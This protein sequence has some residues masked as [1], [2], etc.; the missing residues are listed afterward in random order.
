MSEGKQP[1]GDDV[2]AQAR[3]VRSLA[4]AKKAQLD[5][6]KKELEL[7]RLER[8]ERADVDASAGGPF[9]KTQR[10]LAIALQ[11]SEGWISWAKKRKAPKRTPQGWDEAAWRAWIE[12]AQP[13]G[14]GS[15][16]HVGDEPDAQET[17][18]VELSEREEEHLQLLTG[19]VDPLDMSRAAMRLAGMR[20]D[21]SYRRG[22][23]LTRELPNLI[24]S[25]N[26]LR[27]AEAAAI[28]LDERRGRLVSVDVARV[29]GNALARALVRALTNYETSIAAKVEEWLSDAN[30]RDLP[31]EQ[32][33]RHVTEWARTQGRAVRELT[34]GELAR[35]MDEAIADSRASKLDGSASRT[36]R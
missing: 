8:R 1:P 36:G 29:A 19:A 21:R 9:H 12:T 6:R 3:K 22:G 15:K 10:D 13:T 14:H 25:M 4:L 31:S 17:G 5:L 24:R 20:L 2:I 23:N 32:R 34:R 33:Q 27:L 18:P 11:R 26:A 7:E 28:K 35:V 30:L 16:A